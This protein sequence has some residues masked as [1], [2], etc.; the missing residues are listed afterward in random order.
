MSTRAS[1]VI[2]ALFVVTGGAVG[3]PSP[4]PPTRA[5]SV[6]GHIIDAG[7]GKPVDGVAIVAM[8][9]AIAST[10][11][12]TGVFTLASVPADMQRVEL[13]HPCYF[14]V[15][16]TVPVNTDVEIEIGLPFD[17]ASL[18]RPGCGGLGARKKE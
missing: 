14:R 16:V 6:S 17:N 13:R 15:Q 5:R 10:S 9:A 11:S 1:I 2:I 7:T 8:G 12:A 4:V 18:Q 3:L